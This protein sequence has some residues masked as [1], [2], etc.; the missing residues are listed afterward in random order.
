MPRVSVNLGDQ[1]S[2]HLLRLPLLRALPAGISGRKQ[3]RRL[4]ELWTTNWS[5]RIH[6]AKEDRSRWRFGQFS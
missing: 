6:P 2:V 3:S 5:D 4:G 1:P